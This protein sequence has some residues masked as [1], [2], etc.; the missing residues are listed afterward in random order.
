MR[1]KSSRGVLAI[2]LG[3]IIPGTAASQVEKNFSVT[4][5]YDD[6]TFGSYQKL[7]DYVTQ[8]YLNVN[9]DYDTDYSLLSLSYLGN[10]NLFNKYSFRNYHAHA[11]G[12]SYT[13]QLNPEEESHE[14]ADS[15]ETDSSETDSATKNSAV[16]ASNDSVRNFLYAGTSL[17]GRLDRDSLDYY[18]NAYVSGYA[19]LRWML[20]ESLIGRVMYNANYRTYSHLK[21][22]SNLEN[23][24]TFHLSKVID[25]TRL[26]AEAGYGYKKYFSTIIDSTQLTK[27]GYTPGGIG[28]GKGK[29]KGR[30]SGGAPGGGQSGQANKGTVITELTTPGTSQYTISV[31]LLWIPTKQTE[32]GLKYLRR[33]GAHARY[34]SGQTRGYGVN[35]EIYDDPYAYQSHEFSGSYKQ[36]FPWSMTLGVQLGY[37]PKTYGRPAFSLPDSLGQSVEL[38]S[39]RKDERFELSLELDQAFNFKDGF[40]KTV[41][42]QIGYSFVNNRSNDDF[43]RFTNS[44]VSVGVSADL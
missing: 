5:Q 16:V 42:L 28:P 6:N 43:Y 26:V 4:S 11:L 39:T 1:V 20:G 22:L 2:V 30:S 18:D 27:L 19:R 33:M 15:T 31:G 25:V 12:L 3:L 34:I 29:G 17:A 37:M 38:S 21:D 23:A 36:T 14:E 24:V 32:L 44:V 7:S 41:T 13:L 10:L 35:D 8:L 40:A 9:K